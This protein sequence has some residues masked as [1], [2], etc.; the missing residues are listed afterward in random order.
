M[1][2]SVSSGLL[3]YTASGDSDGSLGGLVRQGEPER[4]ERTLLN[5]LQNA[6]WCSNDPVCMECLQGPNSL[7]LAACHSCTLIAETS[8]EE[9]N[10]MLDRGLVIGTPGD[11][12]VG[13]FAE[14]MTRLP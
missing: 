13:F 12:S 1:S 7:N 8:C 2:W 11:Q 9:F 14:M 10:T 5:A 3:I 4:F 6:R